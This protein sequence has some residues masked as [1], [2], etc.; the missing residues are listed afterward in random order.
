VF[1][2]PRRKKFPMDDPSQAKVQIEWEFDHLNAADVI[3]FYFPKDTLC[4]IVLYELGFQMGKREYG[5]GSTKYPNIF[6]A[7]EPEYERAEDV[8]IQTSLVNYDDEIGTDVTFL[9]DKICPFSRAF[10]KGS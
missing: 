3:V 2:N 5:S 4:P 8:T 10:R 7:V 6:I 9:V 1:M